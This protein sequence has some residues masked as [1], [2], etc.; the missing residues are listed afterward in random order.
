MYVHHLGLYCAL[1][2]RVLIYKIDVALQLTKLLLKK[3]LLL[4]F[5]EARDSEWH[6]H[7]QGC[8]Q[9]C[10]SHQTDNH[11]STSLL[12]FLQAG[13]PSCSPTNSV[14]ALKATKLSETVWSLVNMFYTW[15][16]YCRWLQF[17][18][19]S[20]IKCSGMKKL[21]RDHTVSPATQTFLHQWNEL[22]CHRASPHFGRYSL[23]SH[24]RCKAQLAWVCSKITS[25]GQFRRHLKTH[26]F[27]A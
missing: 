4:L 11:A 8:M 14:K 26:L 10:T 17:S 18:K 15:A 9:V 20:A 24:W 6:W 22:S 25:Y 2:R 7:Q 5:T 19:S 21:T 1:F 23:S 3:L 13:C 16:L 27:R 12:S